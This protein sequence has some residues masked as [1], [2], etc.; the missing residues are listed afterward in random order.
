[1]SEPTVTKHLSRTQ[2]IEATV[3][4]FDA[5]GYDGVTIRS[6]ARLLHCAVGTIYRYFDDK[7]A[8]LSAVAQDR[9]DP[10]AKLIEAGGSFEDSL[11]SYVERAQ[12]SPQLYHLM[13]WLCTIGTDA[14]VARRGPSGTPLEPL[15]S[16]VRRIIAG[17]SRRLGDAAL[18]Q[19]C[20]AAVHGQMA[21]GRSPAAIVETTL[22]MLGH[23]GQRPPSPAPATPAQEEVAIVPA[24]TDLVPET[25]SATPGHAAIPIGRDRKVKAVTFPPPATADDVCLL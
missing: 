17:W 6:I 5:E 13:F 20:W 10:V 14:G 25:S 12:A 23:E 24:V 4:C 7:R 22:R 1:M 15:P 2:I 19:Q 18:A 3:R 9:L 21:L 8:L 11:R 16:V